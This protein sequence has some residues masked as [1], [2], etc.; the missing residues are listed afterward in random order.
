MATITIE[1]STAIH[2]ALVP[3]A[4]DIV[5][6]YARGLVTDVNGLVTGVEERYERKMPCIDIIPSERVP[7]GYQSVLREFPCIIRVMT[8]RPDDPF[9]VELYNLGQIVGEWICGAP[10]LTLPST[11]FDALTCTE[12]PTMA[13]F[14]DND[15]G[16]V[17]EWATIVRTRK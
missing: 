17:M 2:A 15:Y 8:W 6:V 1:I 4:G 13:N 3:L 16:Q 5:A 11:H 10:A 14:G 9:Q 7:N 12:A